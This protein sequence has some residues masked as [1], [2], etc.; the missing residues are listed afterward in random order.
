MALQADAGRAL[1]LAQSNFAVQR[2]PA[3][4]RILM[5]AALAARQPAAAA[6]A[7]EWLQTHRVESVVLQSLA[8]KLG[9]AK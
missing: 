6:P 5:E 3:D 2:E 4:A 1:A 8:S 7:R 9:A